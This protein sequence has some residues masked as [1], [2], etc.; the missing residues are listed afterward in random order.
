[1]KRF[2]WLPLL[3]LASCQSSCQVKFMEGCSKMCA[4]RGV[5]I[6]DWNR[7]LCI[8]NQLEMPVKHDIVGN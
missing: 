1:M 3:L 4:P 2:L 6:A 5:L 7:D 8:C